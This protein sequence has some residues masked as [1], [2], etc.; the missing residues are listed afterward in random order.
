MPTKYTWLFQLI[1]G[2]QQLF[3][4]Y[5]TNKCRQKYEFY[6]RKG[7]QKSD[8]I[9]IMAI[10]SSRLWRS[11]YYSLFSYCFTL[12]RLE[13]MSRCCNNLSYIF[14]HTY[15]HCKTSKANQMVRQI[16]ELVVI[17]AFH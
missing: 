12:Y 16:A 3:C 10:V 5:F 17:V 4:Q 15:F 9:R 13:V 8:A 14:I 6:C 2:L 7:Y 11:L 1:G